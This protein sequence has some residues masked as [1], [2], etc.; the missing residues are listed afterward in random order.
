MA[1]FAVICAAFYGFQVN[2]RDMSVVQGEAGI[3]RQIR[4]RE[5]NEQIRLFTKPLFTKLSG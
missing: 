2:R 1:V 3:A 4:L 5:I